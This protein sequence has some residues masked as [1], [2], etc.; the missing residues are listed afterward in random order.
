MKTKRV[1]PLTLVAGVLAACTSAPTSEPDVVTVTATED[2]V[3]VV[4]EERPATVT[5]TVT[6]KP[7]PAPSRSS[8]P[9]S[10]PRTTG[11][12]AKSGALDALNKLPEKGR[13]PKTGYDRA[14]FGQAW[15]DDVT[16]QYGRNGCDTR[17]DILKRDLTAV[18][19]KPSTNDC[20]ILTGTL[21]DPFTG[22]SIPFTRGVG[23]SNAVQIDHVVALSN[24]WQTGAQQLSVQERQNFANDP[25]NLLAVDGPTNSSKGDGDAATWLPPNKSYRC[26]YVARQVA[27]KKKHNLWVTPPEKNAISGILSGCP[28]VQLPSG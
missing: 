5:K 9:T 7:T 24:A 8:S 17:N 19:I 6:A 4:V 26:E 12:S 23:S 18:T 27:V 14:M 10:T 1:V 16:E 3:T 2:D 13:A 22:A 21:S 11:T 25:L 28:G 20:V 15:T